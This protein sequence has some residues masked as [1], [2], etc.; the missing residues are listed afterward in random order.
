V[1]AFREGGNLPRPLFQRGQV[2]PADRQKDLE[3][4]GLTNRG[5]RDAHVVPHQLGDDKLGLEQVGEGERVDL[6]GAENRQT[7]CADGASLVRTNHPNDSPLRPDRGNQHVAGVHQLS[8]PA[9]SRGGLDAVGIDHT[10]L[11]ID[12]GNLDVVEGLRAPSA[13]VGPFI[14]QLGDV[15]NA[16]VG[17]AIAVQTVFD[18]R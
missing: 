8:R 17:P 18:L 16:H 3:Q 5:V 14:N 1:K 10:S 12:V 7:R 15:R 13:G 9:G 4:A 6:T 11:R 2:L